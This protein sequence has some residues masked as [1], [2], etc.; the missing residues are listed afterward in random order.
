MKPVPSVRIS[1]LRLLREAANPIRLRTELFSTYGEIVRVKLGRRELIYTSHPEHLEQILG[2]QEPRFMR[3]AALLTESLAEIGGR[4]VSVFISND[5]QRWIHDRRTALMS[6]D[7]KSHFRSYAETIAARTATHLDSWSRRFRDHSEIDIETE[8]N[9]MVVDMVLNTLFSNMGV[10]SPEIRDLIAQAS[11]AITERI[12][13]VNPLPWRLPTA[14]R[15]R[16]RKTLGRAQAVTQ[17]IVERRLDHGQ[18]YDDLLG[19]FLYHTR[20]PGGPDRARLVE[21]VTYHVNSL[22]GVG[23]F[24]TATLV[25]WSLVMLSRFP[26]LERQLAAEIEQALGDRPPRYEDLPRMPFIQAFLKEVL[27]LY[28]STLNINRQSAE[29][30]EVA[31][32]WIPKHAD[33]IGSIYHV[34]R[35]RDFWSNPEGFDPQR[36]VDRPLGQDHHYAYVPFGGG[37]RACI[38]RSFAL[39]EATIMV[40]MIVQRAR[41]SMLPHTTIGQ[42]FPTIITMRPDVTTMRIHFKH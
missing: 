1:A 2:E 7:D 30:G 23:F 4:N 3:R 18:D 14:T 39:M 15:A 22:I 6:F 5:L 36:F 8:I 12:R 11:H 37:K 34:H 10:E 25:H 41:L 19:N 33:I 20:Y 24:T 27:R 32:Y 35:H 21:D 16:Y 42:T 31:G 17:A 28:P 26:E 29:A 13:A 40:A 9:T 38:G